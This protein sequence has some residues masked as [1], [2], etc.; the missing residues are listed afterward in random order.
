MPSAFF[1]EKYGETVR[2]VEAGPASLELCGGT[3]VHALGSI[4]PFRILSES[5]IGANTR[6]IEA[7]TGT[8]SIEEIRE[9]SDTLTCAVTTLHTIPFDV[10]NVVERLV[11]RERGL[12]DELRR[13]LHIPAA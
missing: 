4:G 6:R 11:E 10:A 3:H 9:M 8:R 2:V 1:G 12:E 7:T 5:S 13:A